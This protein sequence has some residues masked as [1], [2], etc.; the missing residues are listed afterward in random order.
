L[1]RR[2]IEMVKQ[3]Y[4]N[5][6]IEILDI[7]NDVEGA[8]LVSEIDSVLNKYGN[9]LSTT[10]LPVS[11]ATWLDNLIDLMNNVEGAELERELADLKSPLQA[12]V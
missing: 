2:E 11:V 10:P 12:S 9:Y 1:E 5:L 7:T 3:S 6:I 4:I 8:G